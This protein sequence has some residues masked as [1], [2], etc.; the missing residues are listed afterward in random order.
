MSTSQS[1]FT[2]LSGKSDASDVKGLVQEVL[3]LFK[4]NSWSGNQRVL[5][6]GERALAY[7]DMSWIHH[8]MGIKW[9]GEQCSIQTQ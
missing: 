7:H 8:I 6:R 9:E 4:P 1:H 3:T 2:L 5:K